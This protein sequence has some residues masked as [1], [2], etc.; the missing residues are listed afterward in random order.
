MVLGTKLLH[1]LP[2]GGD[3]YQRIVMITAV[4]Q[5]NTFFI[6]FALPVGVLSEE[7]IIKGVDLRMEKSTEDGEL[8]RASP[9]HGVHNMLAV[10]GIR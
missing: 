1:Y 7:E 3:P 5:E 9:A 10:E 2:C 6:S 8:N 4:H